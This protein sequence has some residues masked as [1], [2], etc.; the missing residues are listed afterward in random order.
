M[1]LNRRKIVGL[2]RKLN[3]LK[4]ACWEKRLEARKKILRQREEKLNQFRIQFLP[5]CF[6]ED[7]ER[8]SEFYKNDEKDNE[9]RG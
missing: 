8:L 5:L 7:L 6:D 9:N 4:K 1:S 3:F 2:T